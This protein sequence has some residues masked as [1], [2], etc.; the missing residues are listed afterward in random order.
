MSGLPR[1]S[2]WT[3]AGLLFLGLTIAALVVLGHADRTNLSLLQMATVWAWPGL[4]TFYFASI[5]MRLPSLKLPEDDLGDLEFVTRVFVSGALCVVS[6]S[7][8]YLHYG[9]A[10]MP[11]ETLSTATAFYFSVVTFATLGYGDLSPAE[12][13][14]IVAA[15]QSIVGN[16]HLGLFVAGIFPVLYRR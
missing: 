2:Q 11:P 5:F 15:S 4:A 8:L 14:R 3:W 9:L 10:A 6:I 12:P 7:I 16:L 13:I 1:F